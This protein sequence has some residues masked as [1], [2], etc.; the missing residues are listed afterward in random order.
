MLKDVPF[1]VIKIDRGL[2]GSGAIAPTNKSIITSVVRLAE[3]LNMGVLCEGVE[4]ASQREFLSRLGAIQAQGFLYARP[5]S[6]E[7]FTS[8]LEGGKKLLPAGE[9]APD[10]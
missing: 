9:E 8:L 3:D 5:M 6:P 4:N 1:D 2:L 7:N 10:A